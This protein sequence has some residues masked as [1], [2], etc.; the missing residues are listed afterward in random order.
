MRNIAIIAGGDSSEYV[1]SVKSSANV[2]KAIDTTLFTPWMISIRNG[3]WVV[4]DEGVELAT[5]NK[6]DFSFLLN[7]Q[8][9]TPEYAYIM[10]HG[11]PGEDGNLQGYFEMLGIPYSSCG[12]QSSALT[13]NKNFCNQYLRSYG[14]PIARS[15]RIKAG[16]KFDPQD[17]AQLLGLPMFVKP[18]AGGSSFGVTKV[19]TSQEIEAAVVHALNESPEVLAEQFIDGKEF[20]CGVIGI[21]SDITVLPVT[22]VIPKKE[23][24]DYE[25]KYTPG[26]ADE[27]TPARISQELTQKVQKITRQIYQLCNCKGIVRVDYILKGETFYF[28]EINTVPGM[29]ATSFIPQ[30]IKAAGMDLTT[31]LTDIIAAGL[32][33]KQA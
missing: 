19:K 17:L 2:I 6:D 27:I 14:I 22:E 33:N 13:F 8:K 4:M 24:F 32:R 23:F 11:T 9:I 3:A 16:E 5:V 15:V 7:G 28:L 1:V 30:Q 29:T 26:M 21:D 12:V 31:V 10:I 20:T 18:S 25:A